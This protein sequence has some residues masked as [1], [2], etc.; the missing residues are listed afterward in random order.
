[1]ELNTETRLVVL[2][3]RERYGMRWT[4]LKKTK[5]RRENRRFCLAMEELLYGSDHFWLELLYGLALLFLFFLGPGT[6]HFLE[7]ALG[8]SSLPFSRAWPSL[9]VIGRNLSS[10]ASS[11]IS[12]SES[13][14]L[15]SP[16]NSVDPRK[17]QE[18]KKG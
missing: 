2:G 9:F 14:R 6:S 18:F 15:L 12:V 4:E 17:L 1:M 3:G 8:S 7:L 11:M 10:L 16:V 13:C 5:K